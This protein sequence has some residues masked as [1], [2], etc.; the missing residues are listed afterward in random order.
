MRFVG[1][2][3]EQEDGDEDEAAGDEELRMTDWLCFYES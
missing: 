3:E 1:D 2:G